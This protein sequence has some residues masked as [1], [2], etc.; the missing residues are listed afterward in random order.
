MIFCLDPGS[1]RIGWAIVDF[2]ETIVSL[3]SIG[4]GKGLGNNIPFNLKMNHIIKSL[5]D[6]YEDL[7][8]NKD[9]SHVAWE[10][11]PSFGAM[12]QRELVQASATTLKVLAFQRGLPY[13]QFTPRSWHK[14]FMGVA[15]VT[16]QEVKAKVL[17]HSKVLSPLPDD[18]PFDTYDAIAIGIMAARKNKWIIDELL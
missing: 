5:L 17:E 11:V 13:Q 16:K 10:I 18:A 14:D 6:F 8:D 12:A 3:G 1:S 4:P 2:D 9:I 7:L 15:K